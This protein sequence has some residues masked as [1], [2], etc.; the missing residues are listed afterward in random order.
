MKYQFG[1]AFW[2]LV[3][4]GL[5]NHQAAAAARSVHVIIKNDTDKTMTFLSGKT[6]HGIVSRKPPRNIAPGG[7]G[8]LFAESNGVATGTEGRVAY[9][10][11]GVNG[12]AVFHWDNPF[13][14]SNSANGEAPAGFKV[15]QIGDTGNRTL[16]FFSIHASDQATARCN[17]NWII[18]HLGKKAE[19]RL[20]G[21]DRDIGFLTTPFK[22]LGIGGWVDTG[23]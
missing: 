1:R 7:V 18:N 22:R 13:V 12:K 19:P 10:L 17:P 21:F 20:D 4:A 11:S 2:I 6:Q 9:R 14:G 5:L 16:I 15:E 23:C 8:E 3:V